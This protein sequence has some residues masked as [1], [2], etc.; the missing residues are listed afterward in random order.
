[1]ISTSTQCAD[2]GWYSYAESGSQFRRQPAIRATRRSRVVASA[3][4]IGAYGNPDVC[5]ITCST[6]MPS[7]PFG[8]NS[9]M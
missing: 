6:V 2:S 9:G 3:R 4:G 8:A 1:M 5:S 7:L